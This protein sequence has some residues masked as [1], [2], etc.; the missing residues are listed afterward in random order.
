MEL[1]GLL[2]C[3]Q[4]PATGPYPDADESSPHPQ[5]IPTRFVLI[6]SSSLHLDRPSNLFPS[7]F[8]LKFVKYIILDSYQTQPYFGNFVTFVI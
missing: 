3:S 6:L 4:E 8:R 7:H 5:T 1:E 2:P